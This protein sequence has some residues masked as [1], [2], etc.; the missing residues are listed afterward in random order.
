VDLMVSILT[1]QVSDSNK[2]RRLIG[3]GEWH[4]LRHGEELNLKLTD[5]VY[6]C[7]AT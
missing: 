1:E 6:S 2:R 7:S 5:G 3:D 4:S